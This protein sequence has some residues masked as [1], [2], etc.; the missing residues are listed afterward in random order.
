MTAKKLIFKTFILYNTR[1]PW[2]ENKPEVKYKQNKELSYKESAKKRVRTIKCT[3]HN[4][5]QAIHNS[6]LPYLTTET[7]TRSSLSI[8]TDETIFQ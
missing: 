5:N 1:Y 6:Q 8:K 4:H 3:S 2:Y 7:K